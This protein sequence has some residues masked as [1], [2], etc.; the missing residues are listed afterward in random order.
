MPWNKTMGVTGAL[1][2]AAGDLLRPEVRRVVALSLVLAGAVFAALFVAVQTGLGIVTAG[3]AG[4]IQWLVNTL[5]GFATV[6]LVWVF[7]PAVA[8][9][10]VGLLLDGVVAA[11]ESAHYPDAPRGR[12]IPLADAIAAGLRFTLVAVT[13]NLVALPVYAVLLF[14]PPLAPLVFLGVNG[15]LLGREYF[16]MVALR[17]H[18]VEAATDLRHQHR[19]RILGAGVA[20]TL[21]FTVPLVNLVAPV[22]GAAAL[23]H[24]YHGLPGGRGST[25]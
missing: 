19:W 17:H 6:A 13:I 25:A 18:S 11:L 16:E 4:W 8:T 12:D 24:L 15:Y 1:L 7:F 3:E 21:L 23:V 2:A 9:F 14:V 10:F 5:G 20:V 22:I